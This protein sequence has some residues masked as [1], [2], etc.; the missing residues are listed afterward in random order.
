MGSY[1]VCKRCVH[2]ATNMEC[3]V[4]VSLHACTWAGWGALGPVW[5]LPFG[6]GGWCLRHWERGKLCGWTLALQCGCR[7]RCCY[8]HPSPQV[9]DKS[10]RDPSEEI[11]ILLRYGQHPNIITLKDVSGGP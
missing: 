1:S 6:K 5:P 9:I 2:K 3:A 8:T 11:E 7:R 4:K 10:K